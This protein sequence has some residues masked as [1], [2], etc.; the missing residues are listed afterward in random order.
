MRGDDVD[1]RAREVM[2]YPGRPGAVDAFAPHREE[3]R[4][5]AHQVAGPGTEQHADACAIDAAVEQSGVLD[6]LLRRDHTHHVA[7]RPSPP[8]VRREPRLHVGEIDLGRDAAAV[9]VRFEQ[10]HR[11]DAALSR[12]H[13]FPHGFAL[14]AERADHADAGDGN[15]L[16]VRHPLAG[17]QILAEDGSGSDP[18]PS[19]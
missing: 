16:L 8:L 18:D 11:A 17:L 5:I 6:R 2:V 1:R 9:A 4:L 7:A 3:E 13:V 15:P 19:T 12:Q 14:R 10:R